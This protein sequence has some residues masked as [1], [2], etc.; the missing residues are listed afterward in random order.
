[1]ATPSLEDFSKV[2]AEP[3]ILSEKKLSTVERKWDYT[4]P[5]QPIPSSR[6]RYSLLNATKNLSKKCPKFGVIDKTKEPKIEWHLSN[7][8]GEQLTEFLAKVDL[9]AREITTGRFYKRPCKWCA[10]C[11]YLPVC[12][13]EDKKAKETLVQIR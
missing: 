8:S 6:C 5:R 2:G 4:I 9:V 11:D 1:V 3:M 7:R 12:T 10:W 13:G